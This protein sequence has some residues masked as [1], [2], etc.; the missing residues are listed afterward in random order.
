MEAN[1]VILTSRQ[2]A[3]GTGGSVGTGVDHLGMP[4]DSAKRVARVHGEHMG[5]SAQ[6]Q[7]MHTVNLWN[8]DAHHK[9]Y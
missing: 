8:T 7:N 4:R 1:R 3:E 2:N 5:I 6:T 9:A